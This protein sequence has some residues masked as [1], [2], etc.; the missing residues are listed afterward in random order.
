MRAHETDHKNLFRFY[1]IPFLNDRFS[2]TSNVFVVAQF[3]APLTF[4]IIMNLLIRIY[5][6]E[7][8]LIVVFSVLS[9]FVSADSFRYDFDDDLK[10]DDWELWDTNSVWQV[11]EGLLKVEIQAQGANAGFFQFKGIPG[12]YEN[13]DFFADNRVI[14]RQVKK[15]GHESFTI[16]VND[17]GTERANF[18]IA[19]GRRFP[20]L[21]GDAPYFYLFYTHRVYAK[22]YKWGTANSFRLRDS[23]QPDTLWRTWELETIEIRFNRGHF[24]WFANDEKRAE[25]KDTGFSPIEIIGFIIKSNGIH[26]GN[27]WVDSFTISGPGLSVSPQ[28]KLA[29]TWGYLKRY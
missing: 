24:L 7:L 29:T 4:T 23:F 18:G 26:V 22:T 28:A 14:Q 9:L 1:V 25:F 5:F 3:I 11:K 20:D 8:V 12:N 17:L 6:L 15:P 2:L 27:A 19:I 10:D 21:P 13:F 16:V